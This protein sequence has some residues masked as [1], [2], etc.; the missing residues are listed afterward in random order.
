MS[1]DDDWPDQTQENRRYKINKTIRPTTLDEL[2]QFGEKQFPVV[3]DP[4]CIRYNEFL[5]E[6]PDAKFF[7]A[8]TPEGAT[9]V[10]CREPSKGVWF[11]PGKGM[12][13]LQS[14]GLQVMAEIV[15]V[16]RGRA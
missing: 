3:T 2:K 1:Y 13:K 7:L 5:T 10:Y 12:G 11:I 16:R 9:I 14:Q 6:H 4:W 8:D 15:D